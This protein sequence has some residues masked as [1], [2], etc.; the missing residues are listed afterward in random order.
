[1]KIGE[2]LSDFRKKV[3][4]TIICYNVFCWSAI[5]VSGLEIGYSFVDNAVGKLLVDYLENQRDENNLWTSVVMVNAKEG[6]ASV[7]MIFV[8]YTADAHLGRFKMVSSCTAAYIVVSV[9]PCCCLSP[10]LS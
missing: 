4:D 7:L 8:A 5:I 3:K 6:L 1:M 2:L 9:N 10:S